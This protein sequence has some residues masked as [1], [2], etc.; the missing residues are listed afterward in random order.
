MSEQLVT[1][2][3][4]WRKKRIG[5]LTSE[6][7]W[8]TLCGLFWLKEGKYNLIERIELKLTTQR[9]EHSWFRCK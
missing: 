2:V 9:R 5:N 1:D 7:G 6:T 4:N 8:L 3:E